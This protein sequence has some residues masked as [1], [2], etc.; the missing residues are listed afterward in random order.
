MSQ[1]QE[2]RSDEPEIAVPGAEKPSHL[3]TFRSALD[4]SQLGVWSWDLSSHRLVWSSNLEDFHGHPVGK[5][6]G[7]FSIAPKELL[8]Q[9]CA[10]LLAA[11]Q[12]TLATGQPCR[13]EYRLPGATGRDDR[14]FEASATVVMQEGTAV[15]LLGMCR[16]ITERLRVNREVGVRARQQEML[17]RLGERALA[18]SDLQKFFNEVV[19]TVGEILDVEMV[20]ILEL[21]PGDAEMLLRAGIGWKPG[22]VGRATISTARDSQAGYTLASGRPVIVENLETETRIR[23]AAVSR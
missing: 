5:L 23:W 21:L 11:L 7:T 17:A 1:S 8:A 13:L 3:E 19:T 20:K 16:E 9:E 18:E 6:G 22:L 4:G 15:Q 14:W 10:G 2:S 12:K